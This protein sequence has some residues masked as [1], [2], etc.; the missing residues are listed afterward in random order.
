MQPLDNNSLIKILDVAKIRFFHVFL[1]A[2]LDYVK[3]E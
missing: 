3:L 1:V 2:R